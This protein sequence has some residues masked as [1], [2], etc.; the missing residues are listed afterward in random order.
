VF[1]TPGFRPL[2]SRAGIGPRELARQALAWRH[3]GLTGLDLLHVEW[4][5]VED[6]EA[7]DLIKAARAVLRARTGEPD[8]VQGNRVTAGRL[9]LRLSRDLRWYPYAR[10]DGDWEPSG[11]P[12]ADPARAATAL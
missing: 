3:G 8:S 1:G 2:P 7:V 5:P 11:P 6:P 12:E 9:Q 4:D 10:S